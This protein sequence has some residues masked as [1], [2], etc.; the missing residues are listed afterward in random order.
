MEV[1]KESVIKIYLDGEKVLEVTEEQ[2][3]ELRRQLDLTLADAAPAQP[4]YVPMPF[5]VYPALPIPTYSPCYIWSGTCTS[6]NTNRP[7]TSTTTRI[8]TDGTLTLSGN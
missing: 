8:N 5:P 4:V 2:A 3:R 6:M 1:I 7:T